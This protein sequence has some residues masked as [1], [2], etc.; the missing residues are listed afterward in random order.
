M[1]AIVK[2]AIRARSQARHDA[3][4]DLLAEAKRALECIE[5]HLP[6]TTFA[7]REGLRAAIA[8]AEA[9]GIKAS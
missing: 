4:R 2:Q 5:K 9:A 1:S 6:P 3:A 8:K 7:P